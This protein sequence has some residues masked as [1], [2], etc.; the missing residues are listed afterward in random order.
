[1]IRLVLA[2]NWGQLRDLRTGVRALEARPRRAG[3]EEY[4]DSENMR[5]TLDGKAPTV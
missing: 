5:L 1:M 2:A 4:F 3:S